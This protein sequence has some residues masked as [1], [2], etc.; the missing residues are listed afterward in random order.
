[1]GEV[2]IASGFGATKGRSRSG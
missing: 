1:M 2:V